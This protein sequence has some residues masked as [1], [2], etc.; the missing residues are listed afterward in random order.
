MPELAPPLPVPEAPLL[1]D[2]LNHRITN[3]FASLIAIVSRAAAASGSEEVK[4]ALRGV[5]QLLHHHA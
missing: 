3:E 2:E 4:R 1:L 5:A